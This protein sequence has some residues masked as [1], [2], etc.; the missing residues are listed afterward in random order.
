[1]SG[2]DHPLFHPDVKCS[3]DSSDHYLRDWGGVTPESLIY[4]VGK[5][6]TRFF[7]DA[8]CTRTFGRFLFIFLSGAFCGNPDIGKIGSRI[9][10]GINVYIF[11]KCSLTTIDP[12]IAIGKF[13]K[14]APDGNLPDRDL[15]ISGFEGTLSKP[16]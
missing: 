11:R 6:P 8:I 15:R 5:R 4:K 13:P 12:D 2:G 16:L 1:M 7:R 10:E 14:R 3:I 9:H